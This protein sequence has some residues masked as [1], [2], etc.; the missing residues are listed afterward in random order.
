MQRGIYTL[1]IFTLALSCSYCGGGAGSGGEKAGPAAME[2]IAKSKQVRIALDAVNLPFEWGEGTGVQGFDVD[3]G[4][5]ICK[6]IGYDAKWVKIPF[7]RL[8]EIL[9]NGEAELVISAIS[10]TEARKKDFAF[11]EPYFDSSNTIAKRKDNEAIKDLAS[12]SGKKVGVQSSTTGHKFAETQKTA[13]NITIVKFAT[14]DDALGGLNRGEVDAVI[15]D[16]P[17][18]TYSMYKSFGNLMT[19]GTRLTSEQYGVMLRKEETELLA[20]VNGTISRMKKS[21]DL[22]ALRKKWFHNV[23]EETSA[24]REAIKKKEG[25]KELPKAVA[26]N[27]VRAPGSSFKMSRL[28]GFQIRL[29][30]TNGTY[31]S[32]PIETDGPRGSCKI[33]KAVPPGQY[34]FSMPQFQLNTTLTIPKTDARSVTFDL[35]GIGGGGI[36]ITMR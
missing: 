30:G 35:T 28:D 1:L 29:V 12:L 27:F 26:F 16:E 20:K 10:I 14:L 34:Q 23:M 24:Q 5:E 3:I 6:D 33:G 19:T 9:K 7:E 25:L 31:P 22:E 18:L 32:S 15:G 17:I 8:F 36:Q 21:G 13:S 2:H 4:N 11:S